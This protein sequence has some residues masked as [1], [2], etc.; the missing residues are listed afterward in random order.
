MCAKCGAPHD[1]ASVDLTA[2]LCFPCSDEFNRWCDEH[3]GEPYDTF[4]TTGV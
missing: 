3:P 4:L 2:L 1:V